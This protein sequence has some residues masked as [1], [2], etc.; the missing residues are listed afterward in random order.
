MEYF[1]LLISKLPACIAYFSLSVGCFALVRD[2]PAF[3]LAP[4]RF[5]VAKRSE[6]LYNLSEYALK[7]NE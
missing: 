2:L 1:V 7:I 4:P 6:R 5:L 3:D